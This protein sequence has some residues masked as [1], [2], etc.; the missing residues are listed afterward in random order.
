MRADYV[1]AS[2]RTVGSRWVPTVQRGTQGGGNVPDTGW[3]AAARCRDHEPDQFFVR[4]AA[5]SRRA[6]RICSRCPVREQCLRYAIDNEIEFG[7]WGG[8]T[9]RQR[10]RLVRN[11]EIVSA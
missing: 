4:G 11:R 8:L 9:E 1:V 10:R 5:Q 7:I 6:V 2:T 3:M